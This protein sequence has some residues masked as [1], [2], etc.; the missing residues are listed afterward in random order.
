MNLSRKD[1]NRTIERGFTLVEILVSLVIF[2]LVMIAV[3]ALFDGGQWIYL[4]GER[5]TK[6]QEIARLALEQMERDIRM[7]GFGVPKG[8]QF[9]GTT[10][11]TPAIFLTT[12]SK[13]WFRGDLD[14]RHSMLT[15]N[16]SVGAT[17]LSVELPSHVCPTPGT[18]LVLL[19]E[20]NRKWQPMTCTSANDLTDTMGIDASPSTG[21]VACESEKCEIFTPDH[22][23]YKLSDD[24]DNNGVCDLSTVPF[25]SIERAVRLGNDWNAPLIDDS[26]AD[27]EAIASNIASLQI[28]AGSMVTV[29]ITV[30]DRAMSAPGQYQDVVLTTQILVRDNAY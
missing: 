5:R 10:T 1:Q 27:Y 20:D 15:Q 2:M 17:T 30:R 8:P 26:T 25:C 22:I 3:Y 12:T 13:L 16:A 21:S 7:C 19:V 28:T 29:T 9:G 4:H 18:S 14:N 6:I 11:W 23:F 24:A